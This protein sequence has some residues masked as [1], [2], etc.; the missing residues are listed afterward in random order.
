MTKLD[1]C[2]YAL[3]RCGSEPILAETDTSK[4]GLLVLGQYE[5]SLT[6]MLYDTT[7]DHNW[8]FAIKRVILE[9]D[10]TTPEFDFKTQYAKPS[11]CLKI[12]SH[13][14]SGDDFAE[15]GDYLLTN[16]AATDTINLKYLSAVSDTTKF[17]PLFTKALS[18]HIAMEIA[19]SLIQDKEMVTIL[20]K[21]QDE[22]KRKA[23]IREA[24]SAVPDQAYVDNQLGIRL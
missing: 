23:V 16:L 20:R 9:A 5:Q 14:I 1:I 17:T 18:L 3:K 21:E 12:I 2:N 8:K 22:W 24:F 10:S 19:Y 7:L 4:R 11:D 13:G 6:E 15:E